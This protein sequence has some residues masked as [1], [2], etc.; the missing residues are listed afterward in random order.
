ME[1][2]PGLASFREAQTSA[3]VDLCE[4]ARPLSVVINTL[5]PMPSC[6][7]LIASRVNTTCMAILVDALQWLDTTVV[8][9][10]VNGFQIVGVIPGSDVYTRPVVPPGSLTDHSGCSHSC[11]N[12]IRNQVLR[13]VYLNPFAV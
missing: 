8:Q 3:L 9:G 6:V 1:L 13:G 4:R 10:F 12:Q 2:G 7:N 11:V 5:A